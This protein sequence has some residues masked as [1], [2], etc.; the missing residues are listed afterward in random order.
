MDE[1]SSD[2]SPVF[3]AKVVKTVIVVSSFSLSLLILSLARLSG[4]IGKDS[5]RDDATRGVAG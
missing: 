2:E 1:K 5:A 4:E 3:F